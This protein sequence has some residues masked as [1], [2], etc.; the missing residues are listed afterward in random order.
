MLL[1]TLGD[2]TWCEVVVLL[3][4]SRVEVCNISVTAMKTHGLE[5]HCGHPG[6]TFKVQKAPALM[7]A[8]NRQPQL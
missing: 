5:K 2:Q 8:S 1:L 7:G 4:K 6:G 3:H